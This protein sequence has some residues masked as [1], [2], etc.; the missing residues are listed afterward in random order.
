MTRAELEQRL[1]PW[2]VAA[3]CGVDATTARRWIRDGKLRA[4][5]CSDG[6]WLVRA[7]EAQAFALDR[8][9]A[10]DRQKDSPAAGRRSAYV[11]GAGDAMK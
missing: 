3:M 11:R 8:R 2:Q 6:T 4:E 9:F 5:S 7:D 1:R 10:A